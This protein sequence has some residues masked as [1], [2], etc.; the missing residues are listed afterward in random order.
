MAILGQSGC[1]KTTLLRDIA[2]LEKPS[3]GSIVVRDQEVLRSGVSRVPAAKRG[4]GMVF[5]EFALFPNLTVSQN[6]A[7]GMSAHN[8]GRAESLLKLAGIDHLGARF[9]A[10]LSGGQQQR[11][12]LVRS[13]APNP[14]LL[15]L[16]EPFANVDA[17]LKQHLGQALR[18]MLAQDGS[19]AVFITHD[20]NDA[21]ALSD[22]VAVMTQHD[23]GSKIS[24]IGSPTDVYL[25]PDSIQ[26]AELT[27]MVNL[28]QTTASKQST[29]IGELR[30]DLYYDYQGQITLMIRP[31]QLH[32]TPDP[33]G[34][35][36][37]EGCTFHGAYSLLNCSVGGHKLKV[38]HAHPLPLK[39]RGH[40]KSEQPLW[41][42]K[43]GF[44]RQPKLSQ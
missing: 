33:N 20:Q 35:V 19:S 15:L 23:G 28:I 8:K 37:I 1:G 40:L 31:E 2:G 10:E 7:F 13:M 22:C 9:P 24:Q 4:V 42:W 32:F 44:E 16:D 12:A 14:R 26:V 39:T 3:S 18:E 25:K 38:Q 21:L 34:S 41:F 11:V 17:H 5:Q 43:N 6:V 27:G 30:L 36:T 29:T